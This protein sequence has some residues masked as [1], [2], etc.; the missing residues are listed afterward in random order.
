MSCAY[1]FVIFMRTESERMLALS[2][3][4]PIE[5]DGDDHRANEIRSMGF[6]MQVRIVD[7]MRNANIYNCCDERITSI[8][9]VSFRENS[10]GQSNVPAH[11]WFCLF[12]IHNC[13][14]EKKKLPHTGYISSIP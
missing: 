2:F 7:S 9:S 11:L 12:E 10:N 14:N 6:Q 8:K 13:T 1:R 5:L 3:T 4:L